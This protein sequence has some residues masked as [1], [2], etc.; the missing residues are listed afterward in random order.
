M[1]PLIFVALTIAHLGCSNEL[2]SCVPAVSADCAPLYAPTYDNV[3]ARTLKPTCGQ[4]GAACHASEGAQA[5]L[6]FAD[7]EATY[8]A[9]LDPQRKL[10][11]AGKDSCSLLVV[12]ID[13]P[14]EADL[15]P[16]GRQLLATERCAIR[17]W[18]AEG[19]AR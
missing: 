2:P 14:D 7:R 1:R 18:I 13:A 17:R 3:Y 10:V 8:T 4:S 9:L 6:V 16:P 12:R 15:M 19:A 11:E 5:D